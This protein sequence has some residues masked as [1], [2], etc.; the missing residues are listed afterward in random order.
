MKHPWDRP[1]GIWNIAREHPDLP[2]VIDCPAG[3]TLTF[4]QLAERA[5][6]AVHALRALGVGHGDVIGLALP[7]DLDILVWQL[8]ASEAGWRYITLNPMA[9]ADEVAAIAGHAEMRALIVHAEYAARA[10]AVTGVPVRIGVGGP[11]RCC[12]GIPASSRP[13][14]PPGRRW[15][16]PRGPRA[17]PRG[18]GGR[19]PRSARTRWPMR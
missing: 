13:T 12:A 10:G 17:C 14:G 16:T 5:H 9:S 4:A 15:C 11:T 6:R 3:E 2:A 8:A 19:C 1:L 18:S 7:N